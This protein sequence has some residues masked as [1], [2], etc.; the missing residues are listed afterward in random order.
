MFSPLNSLLGLFS[1]DIG[2]DL[3]T[4]NTLVNVRN[5]G[6]IIDE[7]S[8]VAIEKNSKKVLAIGMDAKE[9]VGRTPANI[10]AIR[11]LRDGVISDFDITEI[12]DQ[13]VAFAQCMRDNGIEEFE[14]PDFAA[15]GSL[16]FRRGQ[17]QISTVD[18]ETMRAAFEACQEHLEGLAFGPGSIDRSEIEDS[19]VEF[20][21]C[22]RDPE[23]GNLPDFPD[24]DLSN[25]G[26]GNGPGGGPFGGEFSFQDPAVQEALEACQEVFGGFRFGGPGPGGPG[27]GNEDGT[28][29]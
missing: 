6:I 1:Q 16:D 26:P 29:T 18:P 8:V 3:G 28:G 21:A 4:A 27:P 13:L 9:M 14:D 20:A 17:G 7:P 10:V 19:L 5:K 12:Q 24:P 11:P 22:M 23:R 2:I 15:D 25:L